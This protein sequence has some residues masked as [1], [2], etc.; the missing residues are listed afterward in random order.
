MNKTKFIILLFCVLPNLLF[1]QTE[2]PDHEHITINQMS[3]KKS[4]VW[5]KK[6][7]VCGWE[8]PTSSNLVGRNWVV[9]AIKN[10]WEKES[11][12]KFIWNDFC[13][14]NTDIRIKIED[15]HPH[16]KELGSE[17]KGKKDGMVLNFDFSNWCPQCASTHGKENS[18]KFIAVHEFGHALGI[19]HEQN[20]P[21]C[22]CAIEPQGTTGDMNLTPCDLASV[23]NYCNPN[24]NGHGLLSDWDK[25]GI[26]SLYGTKKAIKPSITQI[27]LSDALSD[28]QFKE[29]V[30]LHIDNKEIVI[31]LDQKGAKSETK[32]IDISK[33]GW[34]DY[35]LFIYTDMVREKCKGVHT[36][37]GT[38]KNRIYLEA[39]QSYTIYMKNKDD[40]NYSYDA[41]LQKD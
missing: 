3:V 9:E 12:L 40:N 38:G 30:Y 37:R 13:D 31:N 10:S 8:N 32:T 25:I 5:K 14:A 41:Y 15:S 17:L 16:C 35:E 36:Y 6:V 28:T 20:R 29:V 21:D 34:F 26:K 39:G 24:W 4:V 18:I 2:E 1:G 11:D 7:I 27:K 22:R 19:G 33:S 23:M